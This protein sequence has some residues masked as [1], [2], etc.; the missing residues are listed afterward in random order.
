[1]LVFHSFFSLHFRSGIFCC[2]PP[3]PLFLSLAFFHLLKLQK[4]F[5]VRVFFISSI[6]FR[7]TLQT[8]VICSCMLYTFS[9]RALHRLII[10]ILYSPSDH[11]NIC[12]I[13]SLVL[14]IA[15]SFTTVFFLAFGTLYNVLLKARYAVL[16]KMKKMGI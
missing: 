8:L 1:M 7:D 13:P 9:I 5:F 2:L 4:T 3:T 15:L 11:S 16:N 14:V 12:I 10:V 6:S